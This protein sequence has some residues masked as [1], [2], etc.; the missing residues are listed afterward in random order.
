MPA[1][2][3]EFYVND[4]ANVIDAE[5]EKHIVNVSS[6]IAKDTGA[7]IVV[8]TVTSLDGTEI[9]DYALKMG[10]E[11]GIGDKEKNN[12][13][14]L[15]LSTGDRELR[16]EVGYGLEGALPDG[17]CGRIMDEYIVPGFSDNEYSAGI[18]RGYDQLVYEVC[19][20]YGINVPSDVKAAEM[21][22]E[23]NG[24]AMVIAV[25]ILLVII[26]SIQRK[27]PP[28]Q[29]GRGGFYPGMFYGGFHGGGFGGS[30]G[31]GF[32]GGGGSFGGGGASRKF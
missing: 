30:S 4:F 5:T 29:R 26:F 7:Q 22:E 9:S 23:D 20:E 27:I 28:S 1:P 31:G 8:A 13:V 11:W 16:I 18:L 12:G 21:P 6:Q 17:K 24:I 14:L 25:I 19:K 3:K 10:R 2:T 32:R 15:L